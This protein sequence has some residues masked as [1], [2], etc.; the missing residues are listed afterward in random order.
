MTGRC[1]DCVDCQAIGESMP[2]KWQCDGAVCQGR[3]VCDDHA[4]L[5]QKRGHPL[6]SLLRNVGRVTAVGPY[7]MCSASGHGSVPGAALLLYCLTCGVPV[8]QLCTV[9]DHGLPKHRVVTLAEASTALAPALTASLQSFQQAET[10]LRAFCDD[11]IPKAVALI[12]A[13]RDAALAQIADAGAAVVERVRVEVATL[14]DAVTSACDSKVAALME[15][16]GRVKGCVSELEM[17]AAY[18]RTALECGNPASI[19]LATKSASASSVVASTSR[20]LAADE[21]LEFHVT[22]APVLIDLGTVLT[23]AVDHKRSSVRVDGVTSPA[24]EEERCATIRCVARDGSAAN[25]PDSDI[26][27]VLSLDAVL[28]DAAGVACHGAGRPSGGSSTHAPIGVVDVVHVSP[29]VFSARFRAVHPTAPTMYLHVRVRGRA[30]TGSPV[31]LSIGKLQWDARCRGGMLVNH[32]SASGSGWV[33]TKLLRTTATA[34]RTVRLVAD[35]NVANGYLVVAV[36]TAEGIVSDH[37]SRNP[38]LA[39]WYDGYYG[40]VNTDTGSEGPYPK[41]KVQWKRTIDL[42]FN[43]STLTFAVNGAH[44]AGSWPVPD[45]FYVY[46]YGPNGGTVAITTV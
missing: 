11:D 46:A 26:D 20:E 6:L 34:R 5:H 29:G 13:R 1:I 38:G 8:C 32:S 7:A 9:S 45:A 21:T 36:G 28:E 12:A 31:Q 42:V 10:R 17:V 41:S 37:F 40:S 22:R 27:A 23:I 14:S 39:F 19:A 3:P 15:Q 2:A 18:G 25:I 24:P 44:Q 33:R 16:R 4:G 30:I 43:G 35:M